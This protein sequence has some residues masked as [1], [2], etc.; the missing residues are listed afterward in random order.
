MGRP[1]SCRQPL[2]QLSLSISAS[3]SCFA[4]LES[5]PLNPIMDQLAL[6]MKPKAYENGRCPNVVADISK[7][8]F[9]VDNS[10]IPQ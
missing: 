2:L 5:T 9:E 7:T 3:L 8:L 4:R 1:G 10:T 6:E